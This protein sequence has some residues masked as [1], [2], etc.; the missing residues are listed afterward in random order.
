MKIDGDRAGSLYHIPFYIVFIFIHVN[1]FHTKI[2]KIDK[3]FAFFPKNHL[4]QNLI[5]S[6]N[7]KEHTLIISGDTGLSILNEMLPDSSPILKMK[8]TITCPKRAS[9]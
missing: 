9:A 1:I 5:K 4:S 6:F 3:M 7:F 8:V 2:E